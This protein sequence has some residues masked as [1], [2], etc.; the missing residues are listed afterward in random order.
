MT[1]HMYLAAPFFTAEQRTRIVEVK[2]ILR[3]VND[4]RSTF[5]P[6]LYEP[7][8]FMVL[9]P[10]ATHNDRVKV[11]EENIKQIETA[12]TI[13]AILDER[14]TGTVFEVGYVIGYNAMRDK[15]LQARRAPTDCSQLVV[16][17]YVDDDPKVNVMLQIGLNKMCLG[18]DDFHDAMMDLD[19]P[20]RMPEVY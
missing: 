11:Y 3:Q 7:S 17:V 8:E 14:D 18:L 19:I 2:K 10:N 1:P 9:K 13:I 15:I 16:G 6:T 20:L 12:R 4:K 5:L